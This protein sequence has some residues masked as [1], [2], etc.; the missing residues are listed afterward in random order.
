MYSI[1]KPDEKIVHQQTLMAQGLLCL[2]VLACLAAIS[3]WLL[4]L[5]SLRSLHLSLVSIP[6]SLAFNHLLIACS[7]LLSGI[8][9]RSFKL[10]LLAV[11]LSTLTLLLTFFSML[12]SMLFPGIPGI[13]QTFADIL[14]IQESVNEM[15]PI[16]AICFT[17][18]SV[19]LIVRQV[20]CSPGF[21]NFSE[22]LSLLTVLLSETALIGW[23]YGT[24]ILYNWHL[25]HQ[26]ILFPTATMILVSS[27]GIAIL[28][29]RDSFLAL[30]TK[31][32]QG[33]YVARRLL[34]L[35][36]I[37]PVMISIE[38]GITPYTEMDFLTLVLLFLFSL[39][40]F[41]L[42]V[43]HSLHLLHMSSRKAEWERRRLELLVES[44]DDAIILIS[45]GE[46]I[47]SWNK[48]AENIYGWSPEEMIG[49]PVHKLWSTRESE[50]ENCPF[51]LD[52]RHEQ[53]VHTTK[54]GNSID[55]DLTMSPA[56]SDDE[57]LD[58]F[59]LI[60][61]DITE[62]KRAA[63]LE[64]ACR[65]A[66]AEESE[67]LRLS[68]ELH[69]EIGQRLATA[70]FYVQSAKCALPAR[71]KAGGALEKLSEALNDLGQEIRRVTLEL[72][73]SILDAI[74]LHAA[75]ERYMDGWSERTGIKTV[76]VW[77]G[78]ERLSRF[79]ESLVYRVIQ[80]ALTNAFKHSHA[81]LVTVLVKIDSEQFLAVVEDD[82]VGFEIDKPGRPDAL[83][84]SGMKERLNILGGTINFKS[85][86]GNGTTVII[87]VPRGGSNPVA[88]EKQNQ[89][90]ARR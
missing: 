68:R 35:S 65:I 56:G 55:V 1:N 70:G 79:E 28:G 5:P 42:W 44:S 34:P 80:E 77:Q 2:V 33:G 86:P 74:G 31:R 66:A 21:K 16:T 88:N 40:V 8:D 81:H 58:G 64:T 23:G 4:N 10:R 32:S 72:R 27:I 15:S 53:A 57:N 50:Q 76:I 29:A 6:L 14:G 75:V 18:L 25:F 3:G 45:P 26:A 90:L 85:S 7:A 71:S 11:L 87:S 84:L 67:R 24:Q 62:A 39:P 13:N 36:I 30:I 20:R 41:V 48:G 83:G 19:T 61:R 9:N 47:L 43:S 82:G 59:C 46:N 12:W 17:C 52:I 73:P 78:Q 63:S 49:R 89:S 54:T 60:V 38:G 69:D 37:L 51:D 22:T